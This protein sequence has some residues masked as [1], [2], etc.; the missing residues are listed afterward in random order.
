M[1]ARIGPACSIAAAALMGCGAPILDVT[2]IEVRP[3]LEDVAIDGTLFTP[4]TQSFLRRQH[5]LDRVNRMDLKVRR[6]GEA[7][8]R[9]DAGD[10]E[11]LTFE[12][13]PLEFLVP[14]LFYPPADPPDAF[15]A[16]NLM[17]AE[18]ARNSV[19]FP[20]GGPDDELTHFETTLDRYVAWK[21]PEGGSEY[22]FEPDPRYRPL[23][24]SMV[25][26]CLGPGLWEL[27]ATDGAGEIYHAWF[28]FPNDAYHRLVMLANGIEDE[29]FVRDALVFSTE[30]VPLELDRLRSVLAFE[31]E[32]EIELF[33]QGRSGYSSQGSRKKLA[34]GY[35]LVERGGELAVPERLSELTTG[36]VHMSEF[37]EPGKYSAEKRR[38]FDLRW[39][40]EVR[41]AEVYRVHPKTS[42]RWLEGETPEAEFRGGGY[43][44]I[45][46]HLADYS[47]V[48]GNL[49][50]ALQV[51][52]ED[53][54]I[55]GFG[56]GVMSASEPAERRRL[57]YQEGPSPSFAYLYRRDGDRLVALNSH[58]YG[59]EQVFLRT[60]KLGEKVAFE[61]TLTS[62]E[63]IVDLVKYRVT[64]PPSLWEELNGYRLRYISPAFLTY[65]DDN[66]R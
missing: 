42:Y 44:E 65:Q 58:E 3:N 50:A 38:E 32:A 35:V 66:V 53:F 24:M 61:V 28:S 63:R 39:L 52:Q 34:K 30:E 2:G 5:W 46:I 7:W 40:R 60:R 56:V 15:D 17:M 23:R 10:D 13:L 8:A 6:D 20:T 49:P 51:P 9:F 1:R 19:S 55:H 26:N 11:K 43:L 47:I 57:L 18:Y 45:H 22:R 59:L 21:M 48:L 27:S 12:N 33:D 4:E 54:E 31:G 62:Y 36:P 41:S 16:F 37:V 29:A 25:N 14:R 64:A